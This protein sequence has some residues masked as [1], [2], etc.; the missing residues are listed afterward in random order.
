MSLRSDLEKSD[1]K[2]WKNSCVQIKPI[3]SQADVIYAGYDCQL[4]SEQREFVNPFWFTMGRAYLFREDNLPCI[5]Y[6]ESNE[7]IGFINFTKWL[8]NGDAYSWSY[9]IDVKYQGKG[10]GKA[11]ARLAVDILKLSNPEMQIKLA[12][13]ASNISAHSLYLS[14]GFQKLSEMDGDDLV[15]GF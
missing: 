8:G 11:S 5:I 9:F 13:E 7:R 4:T 2:F 6:N 15:F 1:I 12:A 3:E 14:L 10:Y